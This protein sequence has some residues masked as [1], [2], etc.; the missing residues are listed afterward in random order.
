MA[1]AASTPIDTT[2]KDSVH[3]PEGYQ[4]QN[5]QTPAFADKR[6]HEIVT[7]SKPSRM[8][9]KRKPLRKDESLWG[10]IRMGIVNHQLGMSDQ[11]E[12]TDCADPGD[13]PLYQLHP[14][15]GPHARLLSLPET[16]NQSIFHPF[17]PLCDNWSI[18]PWRQ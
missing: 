3:A 14:F 18:Q 2:R 11:C 1:S 15:A 4:W 8:D 13:R 16:H 6:E 12:Y 10:T 9:K 5:G 7:S 17:L